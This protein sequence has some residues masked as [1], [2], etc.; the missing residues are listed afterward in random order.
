MKDE[1]FTKKIILPDREITLHAYQ[2]PAP[3]SE[4]RCISIVMVRKFWRTETR[5]AVVPK[6]FKD[7]AAHRKVLRHLLEIVGKLCVN[8]VE[9]SLNDLLRFVEASR[10]AE[11]VNALFHLGVISD[12]LFRIYC[13][14]L[15]CFNKER[16]KKVGKQLSRFDRS[17]E[18][19]L[20]LK[21]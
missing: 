19:E 15:N 9:V 7:A 11:V 4:L 14:L 3:N 12:F 1:I 21:S 2:V 10:G 13:D 17:S 5:F 6:R 20:V 16:L 18:K 8:D